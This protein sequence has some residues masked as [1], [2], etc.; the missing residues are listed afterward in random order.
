MLECFHQTWFPTLS[1]RTALNPN[2]SS[3][4]FSA[5]SL[6]LPTRLYLSIPSL[7]GTAACALA[8]SKGI[9]V[10]F[11]LLLIHVVGHYVDWKLGRASW[12][13]NRVKIHSCMG[14]YLPLMGPLSLLTWFVCM[15][16]SPLFFF[17]VLT[18]CLIGWNEGPCRVL[19]WPRKKEKN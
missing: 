18:A 4:L 7:C 2:T 1:G 6:H 11:L 3:F 8:T 5:L 12:Y 15:I 13:L 16:F 14:Y 17:M 19:Y 9:G 10:L